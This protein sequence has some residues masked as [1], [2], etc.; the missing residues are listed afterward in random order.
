MQSGDLPVDL[1]GVLVERSL[2]RFRKV[3]VV[4]GDSGAWPVERFELEDGDVDDGR[5][6]VSSDVR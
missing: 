4:A 3:V 5:S 2:N 6:G 1:V